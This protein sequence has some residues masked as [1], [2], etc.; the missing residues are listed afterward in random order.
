MFSIYVSE[1][2]QTVRIGTAKTSNGAINAA[3]RALKRMVTV[4]AVAVRDVLGGLRYCAKRNE[5]GEVREQITPTG[6]R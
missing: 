1:S 6:K 2:G 4:E 3:R 5:K